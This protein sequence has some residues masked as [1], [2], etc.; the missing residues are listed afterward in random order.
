MQQG[1]DNKPLGEIPLRWCKVNVVNSND[2]KGK[3]N[4]ERRG[5]EVGKTG[6]MRGEGQNKREREGD[7]LMYVLREEQKLAR[8]KSEGRYNLFTVYVYYLQEGINY[9]QLQ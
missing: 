4:F 7:T 1:G 3:F 5:E 2:K 8:L 6:D 9:H